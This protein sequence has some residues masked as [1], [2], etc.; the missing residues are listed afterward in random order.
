[1]NKIATKN[2]ESAKVSVCES[3]F[4]KVVFLLLNFCLTILKCS[5]FFFCVIWN[6]K[7]GCRSYSHHHLHSHLINQLLTESLC[8]ISLMEINFSLFYKLM[9]TVFKQYLP[10]QCFICRKTSSPIG[11]YF[12]DFSNDHFGEFILGGNYIR[13]GGL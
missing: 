3:F 2:G 12:G 8:S 6:N 11:L 10:K 4:L 9:V 7:K 1:M 13:R 5:M